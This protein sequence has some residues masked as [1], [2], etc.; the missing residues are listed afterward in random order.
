MSYIYSPLGVV[1]GSTG[2]GG[3]SP[4]P[5][6]AP[7]IGVSNITF[8][9][10]S[11]G[12]QTITFN[13][14]DGSI[15]GPFTTTLSSSS[16]SSSTSPN[17]IDGIGNIVFKVDTNTDSTITRFNTLDDGT[18]NSS[19]NGH[20]TCNGNLSCNG[21]VS[22]YGNDLQQKFLV[23]GVSGITCLSCNTNN[24]SLS[25]RFNTLDDGA[26]NAIIPGSITSG[27]VTT[28]S[29]SSNSILTS[30]NITS[31][32]NTINNGNSVMNYTSQPHNSQFTTTI[33]SGVETAYI[34]YGS[35]AY[36]PIKFNIPTTPWAVYLYTVSL[37]GVSISSPPSG[38]NSYTLHPQSIL[39]INDGSGVAEVQGGVYPSFV[40]NSNSLTTF[41]WAMPRTN[42]L[43][44][45]ATAISGHYLN[46]V[47]KYEIMNCGTGLMI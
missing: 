29:V 18:G 27:S 38:E 8:V 37:V 23:S 4:G 33:T 44:L 24:N 42:V 32:S 25:S 2:G 14:T 11:N 47:C 30:G 28:G 6:G 19:I 15:K 21:L 35:R 41:S 39:I 22:I 26:G 10:N 7:G 5:T 36:I 1:L 3:G 45:A 31:G 46:M 13:M 40:V 12:T 43:F 17:V 34:A 20:L 16:S 9:N